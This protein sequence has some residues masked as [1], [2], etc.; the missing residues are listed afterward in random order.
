M[1][2]VP[3]LAEE[4]SAFQEGLCSMQLIIAGSGHTVVLDK[5]GPWAINGCSVVV[6]GS[7]SSLYDIQ[8]Y[9]RNNTYS[10]QATGV[11]RRIFVLPWSGGRKRKWLKA[12]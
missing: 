12:S 11:S 2:V 8:L 6:L 1:R 5:R 10:C 3:W 7:K 9:F 4:L